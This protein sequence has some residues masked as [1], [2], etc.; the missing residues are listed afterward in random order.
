MAEFNK[1]SISL[2]NFVTFSLF[3]K[4][5]NGTG[6]IIEISTSPFDVFE[7]QQSKEALPQV[8]HQIKALYGQF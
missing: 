6:F 2:A 3:V 5:I 8:Y 1:N 4:L 7:L